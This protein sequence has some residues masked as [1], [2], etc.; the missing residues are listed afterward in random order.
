MQMAEPRADS[1]QVRVR[2]RWPKGVSGNPRGG[3]INR[4][5]ERTAELF[6]T[7]AGD[8]AELS[9]VDRT[10]LRQA[11]LLLARSERLR[12]ARDA[13]AAIRMSGEARRILT[14]LQR[15][16]KPR[17]VMPLARYIA[18][19]YGSNSTASDDAPLDE[20]HEPESL[21]GGAPTGDGE[22]LP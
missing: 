3:A 8:F 19:V 17:D 21:T 18:A 16:A 10:F 4:V 6:D 15:R 9:A 5:A 14:A 1:D 11:C 20:G 7:M 13:D 22:A 12:R 2:G